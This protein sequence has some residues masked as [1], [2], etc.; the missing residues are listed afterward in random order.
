MDTFTRDGLTFDVTDSGPTAGEVVILLHGFPQDRT[1]WDQVA[2]LL[3]EAGL[4]TLAPDQRG[5][6]PGARPKSRFAYT[7]RE[8]AADA[9]ALADAAGAERFHVVGHDWGGAAAWYLAQHHA[10]RVRTVTSLSTPHPDALAWSFTHSSQGLKSWYM[11]FF[12]LPWVPEHLAPRT[13]RKTFADSGLPRAAAVRYADRFSTPESLTGPMGWY[14][15]MLADPG[16]R[17]AVLPRGTVAWPKGGSPHH[18]VQVPA[19]YVWGRE[20]FAL[21]RAAADKTAEFVSADYEFVEL[22]AGHWLPD[23]HAPEVT[24]AI[25]A[26]IR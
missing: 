16:M 24:E 11:L 21:G 18:R 9:L 5:Y 20:D 23:T 17:R 7:M 4:R 8:V 25:L 2:P 19:T 1:C 15:S 10:A 26:R 12:Q 13:L 6:S 3:N 22:D 14:R